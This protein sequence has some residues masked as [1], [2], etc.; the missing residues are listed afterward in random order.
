MSIIIKRRD[1]KKTK[2]ARSYVC[3]YQAAEEVN[4]APKSLRVGIYC[5]IMH[6]MG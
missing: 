4:E 5:A 6:T 3:W 1:E 2:V